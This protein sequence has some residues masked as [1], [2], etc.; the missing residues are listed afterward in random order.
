[1]GGGLRSI[2]NGIIM[3]T[4]LFVFCNS[5]SFSMNVRVSIFNDLFLSA[6]VISPDR[7][8]YI[9]RGNGTEL[10]S[11]GE[12]DLLY[13]SKIGE[14]LFVS[15]SSGSHGLFDVVNVYS[16]FAGN[17]FNVRSVNPASGKNYYYGTL[18]ISINYGRIS[19]INEIN[20]NLYLAG[21]VEA[22]SGT[23]AEKMFYKAQGVICR[24]YLYKNYSRHADEGF[25]L[26]DEVHCQVYRGRMSDN[27]LILESVNATAGKVITRSEGELIS[28]AFHS[29]CGGQT[30]N[31]EDVWLLDRPYLRSV[32]DPWCKGKPGFS[33]E[34]RIDKDKWQNYLVSM[35]LNISEIT[36]PS[37]F[38]FIR[39]ERAVHYRAG[40]FTMPLTKIRSDL[41]LRSAYFNVENPAAGDYLL[42]RG[43]GHGHGV[44]FCQEGAMEMARR[45]YDFIEIL[46]F[47]YTG[48]DIVNYNKFFQV[49]E[50]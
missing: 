35:G 29:N 24:T 12:H 17:S 15:C 30:S 25:H 44:G 43:R 47:Y 19:L 6:V 14:N 26:C 36:D 33:W 3:S 13:V 46:R 7:G 22:E 42:L 10:F 38:S 34:V 39:S 4:A 50:K 2:S 27:H 21:V 37:G 41:N 32:K 9:V 49:P 45:G 5:H 11:I 20:E 18:E 1:M 40:T 23:S 8:E 28:A 16:N 31:S 48:I